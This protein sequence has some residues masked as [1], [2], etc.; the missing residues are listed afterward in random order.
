MVFIWF[1][2]SNGIFSEEQPELT[3]KMDASVVMSLADSTSD[4][5][6]S[7]EARRIMTQHKK[8]REKLEK[9]GNLVP[10]ETE[11]SDIQEAQ[12]RSAAKPLPLRTKLAQSKL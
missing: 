7:A 3:S 6:I 11:I 10:I 1:L 5:S 4:H 9:L 2:G 12:L 8:E